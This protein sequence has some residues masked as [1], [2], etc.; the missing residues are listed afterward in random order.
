MDEVGGM[1]QKW[2]MGENDWVTERRDTPR[3]AN[4]PR[5]AGR[6]QYYMELCEN[7]SQTRTIYV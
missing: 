5:T 3:R 2:H 6:R 7:I 4:F 1:L